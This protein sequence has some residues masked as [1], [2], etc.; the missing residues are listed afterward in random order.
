MALVLG[1]AS[2]VA[3][4]VWAF[5]WLDRQDRGGESAAVVRV[6]AYSGFVNEWGAG[7]E[8]A[9]AFT[10]ASGISVELLDG[11]DSGLLWTKLGRTRTD[12]AVG[13]DQFSLEAARAVSRWRPAASYAPSDRAFG[14]PDFAAFDWSPIAFVYREGEI[15]PPRSLD[16]LASPRF[17]G[18]LAFPDPRTSSVGLQFLFW[19]LS[20][21]GV[22]PGFELLRRMA[23]NIASTPASWSSAY[24]LFAKGSA[25]LALAYQTSPIYHASAD[26]D[27]RYRAAE[28]S[29]GHPAQVEYV[30]VP[31]GCANCEGAE[32][33][34]RFLLSDSSQRIL[35][36]R[37]FML[38]AVAGSAKGTAFED[39]R[40]FALKASAASRALVDRKAELL[41]RWGRSG[42]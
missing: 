36:S 7:P 26:R 11:G 38:P 40:P 6:L 28:F 4:A 20:E 5:V 23:P 19:I 32:A 25:Q 39:F 18:A 17:R 24:G 16:D 14:E 33:F 10:R 41:E 12:V 3:A 27:S 30:G 34:A 2:L 1:L 42:Q 15:D 21:K 8:L 22:E 29:G 31:V 35:A 13:F 37:N 9:R